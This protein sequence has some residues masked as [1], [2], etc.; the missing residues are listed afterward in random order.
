LVGRR[1]HNGVIIVG[2]RHANIL[3]LVRAAPERL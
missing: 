3:R 1:A 2:G